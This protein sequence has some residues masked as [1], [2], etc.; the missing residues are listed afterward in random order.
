MDRGG[1]VCLVRLE[2]RKLEITSLNSHF[3]SSDHGTTCWYGAKEARVW[4]KVCYMKFP[5]TSVGPQFSRTRQNVT[6]R[7]PKNA[8]FPQPAKLTTPSLK[9]LFPARRTH[10]LTLLTQ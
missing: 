5:I 1:F 2:S 7:D 8:T 3:C 6:F 9:A 10:N 4:I